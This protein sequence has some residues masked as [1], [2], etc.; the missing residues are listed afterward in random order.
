[1]YARDARHRQHRR[2]TGYPSLGL[3]RVRLPGLQSWLQRVA[4]G[5]DYVPRTPAPNEK[6]PRRFRGRVRGADWWETTHA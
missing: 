5:Y 1:M 6:H 4:G 3:P 2:L